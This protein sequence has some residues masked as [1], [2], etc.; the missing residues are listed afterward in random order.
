MS[1]SSLPDYLHD[2]EAPVVK[3]SLLLLMEGDT[4]AMDSFEHGEILELYNWLCMVLRM[5]DSAIGRSILR[6]VTRGVY[7]EAAKHGYE[8]GLRLDQMRLAK[9]ALPIWR[10]GY[11][12][13]WAIGAST[14]AGLL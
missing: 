8:D 1:D 14:R 3:L 2:R 10:S 7:Y 11:E 13:G 6:V 12:D 5:E 9:T 4:E